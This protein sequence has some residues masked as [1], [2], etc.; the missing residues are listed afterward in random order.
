MSNS[1]LL[2]LGKMLTQYASEAT[3]VSKSDWRAGTS[4]PNLP[5]GRIFNILIYLSDAATC[6]IILCMILKEPPHTQ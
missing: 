5:V 3:K 1:D 4:Q 2:L 6:T